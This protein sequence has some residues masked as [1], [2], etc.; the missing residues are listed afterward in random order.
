MSR[1]PEGLH[2]RLDRDAIIVEKSP[3]GLRL[4]RSLGRIRPGMGTGCR[5]R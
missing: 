2:K 5:R 3:H 1:I 4:R